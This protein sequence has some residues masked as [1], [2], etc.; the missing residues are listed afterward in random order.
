MS[1]TVAPAA[2]STL[3]QGQANTAPVRTALKSLFSAKVYEG[4]AYW[5]PGIML[6]T[7]LL[8]SFDPYLSL[9]SQ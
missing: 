2:V 9:A 4:I 8:C 3:K 6:S 5:V 7:E 1:I